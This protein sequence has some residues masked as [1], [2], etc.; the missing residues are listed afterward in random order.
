MGHRNLIVSISNQVNGLHMENELTALVS[1]L[2][3][4]DRIPEGR[5]QAKAICCAVVIC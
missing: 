4:A 2:H 5:A 3:A 1:V